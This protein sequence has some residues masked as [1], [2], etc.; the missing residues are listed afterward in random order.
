M[1]YHSVL[2]PFTYAGSA[3]FNIA[4]NMKMKLVLKAN[5]LQTEILYLLMA[6]FY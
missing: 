2:L 6:T 3:G 1:H 4:P 5:S